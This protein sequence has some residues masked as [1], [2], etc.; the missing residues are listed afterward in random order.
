MT[1]KCDKCGETNFFSLMDKSYVELFKVCLDCD[2][3]SCEFGW[4]SIEEF[5]KRR[6]KANQAVVD[7]IYLWLGK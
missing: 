6:E 1:Y 5:E 4:L 7:H 2:S 3:R